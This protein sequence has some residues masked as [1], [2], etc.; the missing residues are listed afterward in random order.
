[1]LSHF[2]SLFFQK[3]VWLAG[4]AI[5]LVISCLLTP[6]VCP[7]SA[8]SKQSKRGPPSLT[9][10]SPIVPYSWISKT[11]GL[12]L[13]FPEIGGWAQQAD[14]PQ[15]HQLPASMWCR[16]KPCH[17]WQVREGSDATLQTLVNC[18][19]WPGLAPEGTS[20]TWVLFLPVPCLLTSPQI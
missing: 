4:R 11:A 12:Q 14:Q 6:H 7:R 15:P 19:Q 2:L 13:G 1:M 20:L 3:M 10:T 17:S 18:L 5:S 9:R 8:L 16:T